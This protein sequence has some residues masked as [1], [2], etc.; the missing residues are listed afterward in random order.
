MHGAYV[1]ALRGSNEEAPAGV[2]VGTFSYR[3]SGPDKDQTVFGPWR[4][5]KIELS[6]PKPL[7]REA[8]TDIYWSKRTG[9][10]ALFEP[11]TRDCVPPLTLKVTEVSNK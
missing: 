1:A 8:K 3:E 2:L 4:S 5:I 6:R 7:R 9:R 11:N 10:G